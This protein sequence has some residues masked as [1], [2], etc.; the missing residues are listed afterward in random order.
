M[1]IASAGSVCTRRASRLRASASS[2]SG[3][4]ADSASSYRAEPHTPCPSPGPSATTLARSSIGVSAE[5]D[6]IP[7]AITSGRRA[8]SAGTCAGCVATLT[9]PAPQRSAG[10]EAVIVVVDTPTKIVLQ[11][12]LVDPKS[13]HVTKHWRQGWTYEA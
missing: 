12:V 7:R 11:H 4:E 3:T 2:T 5:R 6:S 13:G 9:R 8:S 1:R 10:N